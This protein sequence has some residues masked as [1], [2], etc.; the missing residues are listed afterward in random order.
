MHQKFGEGRMCSSEDMIVDRQIHRH[1]QTDTLITILRFPVGG[2]SNEICLSQCGRVSLSQ[3][4]RS[5]RTTGLLADNKLPSTDEDSLHQTETR[6]DRVTILASP[7]Y[8]D[9]TSLSS[10]GQDPYTGENRRQVSF[11]SKARMETDQGTNSLRCQYGVK[12]VLKLPLC[13]TDYC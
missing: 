2:R 12:V 8:L 5:R 9:I 1:R 6:T 11:W 7:P 3:R 10:Y 13:P 4:R